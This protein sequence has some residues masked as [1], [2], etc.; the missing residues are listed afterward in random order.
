MGISSEV[1]GKHRSHVWYKLT[2][3][4]AVN[5]NFRG[6]LK[7]GPKEYGQNNEMLIRLVLLDLYIHHAV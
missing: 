1:V 6:V 5:S 3:P 2:L 7:F 4:F